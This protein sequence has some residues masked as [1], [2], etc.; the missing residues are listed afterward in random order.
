MRKH[1]FLLGLAVLLAGV[2]VLDVQAKQKSDLN[3]AISMYKAGNYTGCIQTM[4]QVLKQDPSNAVAHY[5]LAISNAQAGRTEEAI[6]HYDTVIRLNTQETLVR[7]ATRGKLCL[8]DAEKCAANATL[9]DFIHGNRGFDLT[10]AVKNS[11]ETQKIESIRRDINDNKDI[12]PARFNQY[13]RFSSSAETAPSNDEIVAALRVLQRAGFNTP[14][15]VPYTDLSTIYAGIV[16]D[17]NSDSMTSLM[18]ILSST[19]AKNNGKSVDPRIL[20]S[21]MTT[22]M[23]GL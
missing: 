16:P 22:Q 9:D 8:E 7:Y 5:Y 12:E 17:N 10:N 4:E 2:S 15:T 6:S 14:A 18:N 1:I 19:S 23:M 3:T 21:I 11:I 13:K 20:Q